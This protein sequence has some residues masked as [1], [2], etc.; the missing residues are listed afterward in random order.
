M[1]V[2]I[3]IPMWQTANPECTIVSQAVLSSHMA[4]L[5]AKEIVFY[6]FE[7]I[8]M[9]CYFYLPFTPCFYSYRG[10][11]IYHGALFLREHHASLICQDWFNRP[12]F[13]QQT[14][15]KGKCTLLCFRRKS[16]ASEPVYVVDSSWSVPVA[17]GTIRRAK[18][19]PVVGLTLYPTCHKWVLWE[20][21][22]CHNVYNVIWAGI[23]FKSSIS[24]IVFCHVKKMV[25]N[26]VF[27]FSVATIGG[28]IF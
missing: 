9:L 1:Y 13:H 17:G 16:S 15:I 6:H 7:W 23:V 5:R 25:F 4:H 21:N 22:K 28:W 11:C 12:I 3:D 10:M 24:S 2:H 19:P 27:F 20:E 26:F 14:L 8:C 18:E